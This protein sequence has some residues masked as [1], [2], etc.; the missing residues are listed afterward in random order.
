[1]RA[2]PAAAVVMYLGLSAFLPL[3][4]CTF[5]AG[6]GFGTMEEAHLTAAFEPGG[7]LGDDGSFLTLG[8]YRVTPDRMT[9][10]VYEVRLD[11][12]VSSGGGGDSI[13]D[14]ASPPPGYSL[15]HG[16][17]CHH[18]SGALVSYEDI[19][20]SL[21]EGGPSQYRSLV[22]M[23][24]DDDLDL[25]LDSPRG[26]ERQLFEFVPSGELGRGTISRTQVLVGSFRLTGTATG[27]GLGEARVPLTVD[28]AVEGSLASLAATR[29]I[30]PDTEHA[31][32]V[33][34]GVP[35][36][37]TFLDGQELAD[38]VVDGAIEINRGPAADAIALELIATE[39]SVLLD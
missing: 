36:G 15:C 25:L 12:L 22:T 10:G 28:V 32:R 11:E 14:P 7:R 8:G 9:L 38:L 20:A 24:V 2:P 4:A 16:G 3:V 6:V 1:M 26:D 21:S 13:F 37:A 17:H 39:I 5:D 19:Q 33:A 35:V 34:V 30:G 18:E 23:A 29:D 31:V 27:G